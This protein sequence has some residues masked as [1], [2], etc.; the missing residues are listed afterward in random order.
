MSGNLG[1]SPNELVAKK[2][3][4]WCRW[5]IALVIITIVS[6]GAYY[7]LGAL[8]VANQR[9]MARVPKATP[10]QQKMCGAV[11]SA[12]NIT[13]TGD[14]TTAKKF[15]LYRQ[16]SDPGAVS[17]FSSELLDNDQC[18]L[19]KIKQIAAH[20]SPNIVVIYDNKRN[21]TILIIRNYNQN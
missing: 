20:A 5:G 8:G 4:M 10:E 1:S 9:L 18:A 14:A 13:P 16:A 11:W 21:K 3:L 15:P 7:A 19:E 17:I 12:T 2:K 6:V